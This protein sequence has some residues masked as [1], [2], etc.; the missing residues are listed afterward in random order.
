[1]TRLDVVAEHRDYCPWINAE[2]QGQGHTSGAEPGWKI[3][4]RVVHNASA[5]RRNELA[6]IMS[7]PASASGTGDG[8]ASDVASM[9]STAE[10]RAERDEKDKERFAKLKRLKKAFTVKGSK[11][12]GKGREKEKENLDPAVV[13]RPQSIV[14]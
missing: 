9:L 7:R 2:S 11:R 4:L 6:P 14:P 5:S 1:M 12:L 13:S 3:L 10:T 8:D